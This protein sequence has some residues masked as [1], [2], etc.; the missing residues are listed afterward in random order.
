MNFEWSGGV[1]GPIDWVGLFK[2]DRGAQPT[3]DDL[4]SGLL[5]N[6]WEWVVKADGYPELPDPNSSTSTKSS[7]VSP[8]NWTVRNGLVDDGKDYWVGYVDGFGRIIKKVKWN[9]TTN[10]SNIISTKSLE[11]EEEEQS[12]NNITIYPTPAGDIIY[13][14]AGEISTSTSYQIFNVYGLK[15]ADGKL[16]NNEMSVSKLPAGVY[17]LKFITEQGAISKRFIKK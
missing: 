7:S 8:Y 13:V 16:S 15:I 12:G 14:E 4:E 1:Q 2:T 3:I 10:K 9:R 17:I 11:I 6:G 5:A